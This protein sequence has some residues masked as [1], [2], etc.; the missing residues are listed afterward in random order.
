MDFLKNKP[1][2][3]IT[4]IV[5]FLIIGLTSCSSQQEVKTNLP[6]ETESVYFQRWIGGQ[7]KTGTG[8]NF[9][10][11]FYEQFPPNFHLKKVYFRNQEANFIKENEITFVARFYQKPINSDIILDGNTSNEYSNNPPEIIKSKFDLKDNE[12]ILEFEKDNKIQFFKINS[13]KEKE[14][15]AYPSARPRN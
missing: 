2:N 12:A 10:L 7:E 6:W 9:Y 1:M 14:L 5:F 3:K 13:V 4:I 11:K 8:I 15:L